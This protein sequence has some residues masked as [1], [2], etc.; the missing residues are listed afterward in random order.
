V[1]VAGTP[2]IQP[3]LAAVSTQ[4]IQLTIAEQQLS[5]VSAGLPAMEEREVVTLQEEWVRE[6][7][8]ERPCQKEAIEAIWVSWYGDMEALK[9]I[10]PVEFLGVIP[11]LNVE[12][13]HQC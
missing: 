6:F 9:A 3:R 5:L 10:H 8:E 13:T 4:A 12:I 2:F 11:Y 1:H 7:V